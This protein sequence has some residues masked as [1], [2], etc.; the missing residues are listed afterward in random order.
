MSLVGSWISK[1]VALITN[2][3]K[4]N[5]FFYIPLLIEG[6]QSSIPACLNPTDRLYKDFYHKAEYHK[7]MLEILRKKLLKP[8]ELSVPSDDE[9]S[10]EGEAKSL[11]EKALLE[12]YQEDAEQGSTIAQL[13]LAYAYENGWGVKKNKK[14]FLKWCRMAADEED[15]KALT[16]LG[17]YYLE[18][19]D[20]HDKSEAVKCFVKATEQEDTANA[21]A[22][23]CLG[24]C[25]LNGI[26]I[27]K[28]NVQA[29]NC[30]KKAAE[31]GNNKAKIFLGLCYQNGNG[32]EKNETEAMR[33][34]ESASY[35]EEQARYCLG[36][37]YAYGFGTDVDLRKA[38]KLWKDASKDGNVDAKVALGYFYENGMGV[39]KDVAEAIRFYRLGVKQKNGEA[40]AR[41]GYCYEN[42][43]GVIHDK[44]AASQLYKDAMVH[45]TIMVL[46]YNPNHS[47]VNTGTLINLVTL[48][49]MYENLAQQGDPV[50]QHNLAYCYLRGEGVKQDES[51]GVYWFY[52]ATEQGFA[53]AQCNLGICY[54]NGDGGLTQDDERA[55]QLYQQAAEQ[56]HLYAC[57]LLSFCFEHGVG[58]TQNSEAA[59][60]WYEHATT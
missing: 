43:I 9:W 46:K 45:D 32:I 1:E 36:F 23:S 12:M 57:I 5:D 33:L 58:V 34:F 60:F 52:L 49:E 44:A 28:D 4:R 19:I 40:H 15:V 13:S 20:F 42:G 21:E 56:G 26:G 2:R 7:N 24:Y 8:E 27:E 31:Q 30:F 47:I 14:R 39:K 38:V 25:Y 48:R 22:Y 55:A 6:E 51:L 10:D 41:L 16:R 50:A 35:E 29:V 17:D 59:H 18:A 54:K 3:L 53:P 11:S 37:C